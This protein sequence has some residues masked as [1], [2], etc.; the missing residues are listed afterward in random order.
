MSCL[1]ILSISF[2]EPLANRLASMKHHNS[3][4]CFLSLGSVSA[5]M[6]L[7]G[8]VT[9]PLLPPP[10]L[11]LTWN[12]YSSWTMCFSII[13]IH[14]HTNVQAWSPPLP[15]HLFPSLFQSEKILF[16]HQRRRMEV[17]HGGKQSSNR[18]KPPENNFQTYLSCRKTVAPPRR[19]PSLRLWPGR[20]AAT[21]TC[22]SPAAP[23]L[24]KAMRV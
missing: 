23:Y 2:K 10:S 8:A 12:L 19:L 17:E 21:C 13:H 6:A 11:P 15:Q 4:C 9:A 18:I 7:T 14:R 5:L 3:T 22:Q 24:Q 16:I 20:W 1:S